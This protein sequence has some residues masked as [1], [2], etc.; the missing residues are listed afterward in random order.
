MSISI[1]RPLN[2][3]TYV[4]FRYHELIR[5]TPNA[6]VTQ[7]YVFSCNG[8]YD[9]DIT[10]IGHQPSGFDEMMGLFDHYCV[11]KSNI[12][13]Q[14]VNK[15]SAI[16]IGCGVSL[17]DSSTVAVDARRYVESGSSTWALLGPI[18]GGAN[19][20]TMSQEITLSKYL[21]R[22]NILS[23]D[24]CSGNV[25][26]NPTEQAYYHLWV[27]GYG[28]TGTATDILVTIDYFA[29]LKE[30]RVLTLS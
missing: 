25:S 24:D 10:G 9:P 16:S 17:A 6:A 23:E 28:S 27:E 13:A 22:P 29:Y 4:N 19:K 15:D 11:V 20:A 1:P 26:N 5:I 8:L 12:Q 21:G 2:S 18:N 14:F 7:V 3:N 30:P